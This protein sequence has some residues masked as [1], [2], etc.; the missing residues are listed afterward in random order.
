MANRLKKGDTVMV[1]SGKDKGKKGKIISVFDDGIVVEKVNVAKK[2]QKATKAFQGGI[3]EKPMAVNP[4]KL[5]L[6]CQKCGKP[7]RVKF[8]KLEGKTV[9]KCVK[10]KEIVD[11]VK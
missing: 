3:I 2:H 5:M 4:S 10:C 11:K 9:R 6:I 1:L 7:T 8:E